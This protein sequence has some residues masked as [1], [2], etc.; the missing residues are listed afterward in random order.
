MVAPAGIEPATQGFSVLCSTD[1]ATKP[2]KMAVPTRIELAIFCVTGRRDNRYTTEP[3]FGCGGRIWTYDLRVMSPTSYQA[4]PPR[5]I[6]KMAEKEGF[7]PPRRR[8]PPGFQDRS[9]Q[10]DLGISPFF[11]IQMNYS[12]NKT[13]KS[14]KKLIFFK[15]SQ[16]YLFSL[17]NIW[18]NLTFYEQKN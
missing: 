11:K 7:E 17:I 4:A 13:T 5:D 15:L 10:P 9:L 8:R 14:T 3:S 6:I 1:W 18:G 12:T 16:I 2:K